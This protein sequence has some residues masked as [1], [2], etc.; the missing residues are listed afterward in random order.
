[1]GRIVTQPLEYIQPTQR[2][3]FSETALAHVLWHLRSDS[4]QL[5]P[6]AVREHNGRGVLLDGRHR[7]LAYCI[8]G[9]EH[10]Q[11]LI[12]ESCTDGFSQKRWPHAPQDAIRDANTII[13]DRWHRAPDKAQANQRAGIHTVQD[14]RAK[15][16]NLRS[17]TYVPWLLEKVEQA[18]TAP[19]PKDVYGRFVP[20][21]L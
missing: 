20:Q 9:R 18:T 1:M 7:L 19:Y 10:I 6:V 4:E 5:L 12:A 15:L 21:Q 17:P 11:T 2:P 14:L 16:P 8:Q 13:R 3:W